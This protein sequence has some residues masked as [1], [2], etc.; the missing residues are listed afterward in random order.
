MI[1]MNFVRRKNSKARFPISLHCPKIPIVD[2]LEEDRWNFFFGIRTY[3]IK[4]SAF[5]F[6]MFKLG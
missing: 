6:D 1:G 5:A 4:K 3:R 2:I